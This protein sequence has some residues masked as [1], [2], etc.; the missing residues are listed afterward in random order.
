MQYVSRIGIGE[1][2]Y[3]SELEDNVKEQIFLEQK[4]LW[5]WYTRWAF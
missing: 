3:L 4:K 5:H 1:N 2:L